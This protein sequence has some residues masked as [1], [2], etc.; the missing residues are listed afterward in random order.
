MNKAEIAANFVNTQNEITRLSTAI[1]FSKEPVEKN[2]RQ[3]HSQL[4]MELNTLR[5]LVLTG[6]L[7]DAQYQIQGKEIRAKAD[8]Y[9][10]L[11]WPK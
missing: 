6:N 5:L 1:A 9:A 7:L 2:L 4:L 10:D 3:K 11:I 8:E